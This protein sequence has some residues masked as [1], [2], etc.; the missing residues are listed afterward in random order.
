MQ[1]TGY[2]SQILM[3]LEFSTHIFG[4]K[5]KQISNVMK[6]SPVT[7]ELF[8]ADRYDEANSRFSQFKEH[9]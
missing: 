9:D 7:V 8:H 5:K 4:E 3:K 1:S 6:I 2:S